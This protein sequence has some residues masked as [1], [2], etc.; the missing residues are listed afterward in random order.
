MFSA[1]SKLELSPPVAVRRTESF[2]I[3]GTDNPVCA[4]AASASQQAIPTS[5]ESAR[6]APQKKW[7][8]VPLN[9]APISLKTN[10]APT[11]KV[12][13][14]SRLA[15]SHS[16]LATFD[17][18]STMK[19]NRNRCISMKINDRCTLY[20]TIIPGGHQ[21]HRHPYF[22]AATASKKCHT[23]QPFS[24]CKP[25]KTNKTCAKE[26]SQNLD[27]PARVEIGLLYPCFFA[28]LLPCLPLFGMMSGN[29]MAGGENLDRG[30]T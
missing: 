14:F 12:G 11:N 23:L 6:P 24:R 15:A 20:S 9:F 4:P 18:Y 28:S 30:M 17:F 21:P 3:G 1:S 29:R 13:H 25:L 10:A 16:S 5:L 7:D 22:E 27:L 26:V 19:M 2:A 8:T